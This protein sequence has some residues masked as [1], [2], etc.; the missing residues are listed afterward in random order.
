MQPASPVV[1]FVLRGAALFVVWWA[2]TLGEVSG[3]GF[4]AVVAVLVAWLSLRLFPPSGF[5]LRPLGLLLFFGYFLSRSVVAGLDVARRLLSPAL[6]V[7]PGE[8]IL[9]LRLPEG[10]PRWLLANTLS[11]M[12]G[13]LSALLEGDQ[14][15]LHCL[16][17]RDPVERDVRET[18]RQ[19]GR[20]FGLTFD[21]ARGAAL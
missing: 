15:T 1:T 9:T 20:V 8:I 19:V 18:E 21:H 5:R 13:T 4:G 7:H 6:P 11:L 14:L 10:S 2:L 16:D 17:T 3:L 12:P